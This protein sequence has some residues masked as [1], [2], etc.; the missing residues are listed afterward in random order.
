MIRPIRAVAFEARFDATPA[1]VWKALTESEALAAWFAPHIKAEQGVGGTVEM[2][3]DPA[4]TWPT[5]IEIWDPERQLRWTDDMPAAEDGTPQPRLFV[6]WSISTEN[7]Q[8]VL[9]LVHSGFG[10]DA[11]WDDQID[12]LTGGWAYFLW[13]MDVSLTRH[14]DVRRTMVWARP[15]SV[16]PRAAFWQAMFDSGLITR[17]SGDRATLRLGDQTHEMI[18]RTDEASKRFAA[19]I[20]SLNDALLFIEFEGAK[21]TGFHAGFW[22][23]TYG[24]AGDTT[25]ALQDSLAEAVARLSSG[26]VGAAL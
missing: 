21:D 10:E 22:L 26:L 19:R 5:Q 14:R 24:L 11:K 3:W 20:P 4:T 9:R 17:G 8:T 1:Q 23:S 7:G 2:G 13:N 16:I 25:A 12:G 18:V 6:D 15:K